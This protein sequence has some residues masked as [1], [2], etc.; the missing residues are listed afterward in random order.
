MIYL[1]VSLMFGVLAAAI[2]AAA[3]GEAKPSRVEGPPHPR[4]LPSELRAPEAFA[5]IGDRDERSRALFTEASRVIFHA[6]CVNCHP[7]DDSPRQ[8]ERAELHDPPVVR[9]PSDRGVTGMECTSCHQDTNVPLAR[10]PGASDWHLAPKVM[11]WQS[12]TPA[13]VCAQIKDPARNG[14]KTL[15]QIAD[16][17]AH[18][19]L[20]AWGWAPGSGREPA[21]GSQERFGALVAAWIETGAA[22]P[23]A[24]SAS[25]ASSARNEAAQ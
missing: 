22:C 9:G 23:V 12:R 1:R 16:H 5:G 2:A 13:D 3:C 24:S 20:V 8:R 15:A 14:G 17:S 7:S 11:A 19:P 4:A 6:R 10:V 25:S 21:P 18:D